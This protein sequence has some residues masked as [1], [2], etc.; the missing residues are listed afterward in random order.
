MKHVIRI[1]PDWIRCLLLLVA[2]P[3]TFAGMTLKALGEQPA[4][5]MRREYY[6]N[7]EAVF[8]AAWNGNFVPR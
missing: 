1:G 6:T 8:W 7:A 4:V 2:F 3:L 5:V